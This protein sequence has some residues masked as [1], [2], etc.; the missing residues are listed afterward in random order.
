MNFD[1]SWFQI[2]YKSPKI[3]IDDNTDVRFP[4]ELPKK[5]IEKLTK[6]GDIVFDPFAGYGTT[7]FAAQDLGRIG[8]GIEYE[9]NRSDFIAEKLKEPSK[10]IHGDSRKLAELDL[11]QFD[12]CFT[13]PPYMRSFDEENPLTNY[14]ETGGYENYLKG[15][16]S[17][18]ENIK[19][20][21]KPGA[22][23]LVEAENTFEPG[24]PMTPLA[25]DLGK[26]LSEIFLLERELICCFEEGDLSTS[27]VNHST[28]LVLKS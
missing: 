11:P 23:V 25:W 10:I 15:M 12:L 18:F 1:K 24:F 8:V 6:P 21:M 14:H 5:F 17:I 9:K 19:K 28:I 27:K 26:V 7:L 3:D 22:Y 20:H 4:I 2:S 16:K 13:S